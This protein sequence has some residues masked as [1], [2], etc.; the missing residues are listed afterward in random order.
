M[1]LTRLNLSVVQ[2][3]FLLFLFAMLMVSLVCK[4][5]TAGSRNT[6]QRPALGADGL[7][8]S[9]RSFDLAAVQ[10]ILAAGVD[11]NAKSRYG[12][13]ALVAA[14]AAYRARGEIAQLL[15]ESGARVDDRSFGRSAIW[16]DVRFGFFQDPLP[17]YSFRCGN[18]LF[19]M[20]ESYSKA[21]TT[22]VTA[23]LAAAAALE[24]CQ[25]SGPNRTRIGRMLKAAGAKR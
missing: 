7:V 24:R 5:Q 15:L 13:T 25:Y 21:D 8:Q 3:S 10:S 6:Q 19:E 17:S 12:E 18:S 1:R 22:G 23:L 20:S 11:V 4:A 2:S 16:V 9:A 14:A